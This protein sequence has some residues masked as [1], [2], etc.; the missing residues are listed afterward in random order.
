MSIWLVLTLKV[1]LLKIIVWED[2]H[3]NWNRAQNI[4]GKFKTLMA[5][6]I[7]GTNYRHLSDFLEIS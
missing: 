6:W 5:G 2:T 3:I 7:L 1:N 4:V